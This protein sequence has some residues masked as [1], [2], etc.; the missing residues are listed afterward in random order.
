MLLGLCNRNPKYPQLA[1][2]PMH[3][4]KYKIEICISHKEDEREKFGR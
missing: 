2:N 1:E 3:C 4:K